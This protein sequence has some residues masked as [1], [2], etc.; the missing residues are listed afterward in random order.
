MGPHVDAQFE[1]AA[2]GFVAHLTFAPAT[3]LLLLSVLLSQLLLRLL[4]LLLLFFLFLLSF[5]ILFFLLLLLRPLLHRIVCTVLARPANRPGRLFV[6]EGSL[7]VV[8]VQG[9]HLPQ[10]VERQ[11]AGEILVEGITVHV[12]SSQLIFLLHLWL[13]QLFK[14]K[15]LLG[16][17][18]LLLLGVLL[19]LLLGVL[20]LLQQREVPEV[21][22]VASLVVVV[23]VVHES[24]VHVQAAGHPQH[25]ATLRTLLHPPPHHPLPPLFLLFL[26]LL[27][28]AMVHNVVLQD[29][30]PEG[31]L[32][33]GGEDAVDAGVVGVVQLRPPP[34]HQTPLQ[35]LLFLLLH[36]PL[37]LLSLL[38]V[39]VLV[40]VFGVFEADVVVEGSK[41]AE[42]RPLDALAAAEGT[43]QVLLAQRPR[44][45]SACHVRLQQTLRPEAPVAQ[46]T[47]VPPVGAVTCVITITIIIII[48]ITIIMFIV[49][50][51]TTNISFSDVMVIIGSL[52]EEE[53]VRDGRRRWS[54]FTVLLLHATTQPALSALLT[55]S[56]TYTTI[57]PVLWSV[58]SC[59]LK[60]PSCC[61]A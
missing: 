25:R 2:E 50:I 20:L 24:Q 31:D 53:C 39:A 61:S 52:V 4:L 37:S 27:S 22:E 42:G 54:Y 33:G 29:V 41:V 46:V 43:H 17:F 11:V 23:H 51:I 30:A 28:V 60:S 3:L 13:L 44:V 16:V 32:V 58:N 8:R 36:C 21:E 14:S 57:L 18:L 55:P 56:T 45:V 15:L 26:L 59:H 48:T 19:L 1:K 10:L 40:A 34:A 7:R 35:Q 6:L 12:G 49:I 5:L 47:A 9:R 38:L